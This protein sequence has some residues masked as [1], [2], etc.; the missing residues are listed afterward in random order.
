MF[1]LKLHP[2][3]LA[4][5]FSYIVATIAIGFW[6][7]KRASKS[8]DNYFLGGNTIPWYMLGLS[9]ASGMFD[10]SG[11]MWMVYLL[12]VYGLKSVWIPWLWPT[13]NQIF[14]MV[15]LSV[16]LRRSGVMTGAEW[17]RFRFGDSRG[18]Q[19][20]HLIVVVFALV[21]V[22]GFLAYGFIGI[23]KFTAAFLP[24]ELSED[25]V[26]NANYYG[27][28]I[29]A[30]TTVYVVK[31]GMFSVVFTEV[32][33]FFIMTIACIWVGIIAMIEVSP[34]TLASVVPNGWSDIFFG[35][36]LDLDWSGKLDAANDKIAAD[37]WELFTLFIMMT[38]FKG[39]LQSLAGPA[40]NYDMQRVLSAKTPREAAL[41]SGFV[42]LVL[43]IPRYM[44]IAGLTV[45]A[46]AHFTD[47]LAAQGDKIDFELILPLAMR[48]FIPVGLLGLLISALLAAFMSTYAATVNAAPAYVVNDIYKRYFNPDA[49]EKTYVRVS[50][51]TS[52]IVVVIGTAF[53]FLTDSLN[54]IVQWIVT[55]LYG[56][57]AAANM[58]KWI[59]WR[60]NSY[61]YFWGMTAGMLA[62]GFV[63]QVF[64]QLAQ[65][66]LI[67]VRPAEIFMFPVIL[68]L[69]LAGCILGTL[70][71]PPDD[72]ETLKNF[73]RRVRPWGFWK[74]IHKLVATEYPDIMA[75]RDL[76]R[77]M[78]NVVVGIVWQIGLTAT[79]IFLVIRDYHSLTW[80]V[81]VVLVTS[82]ILKQNWYDRL[83]DYPA[84]LAA[85]RKS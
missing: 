81:G 65:R 57:Y 21:N 38:L 37:G 34:E 10:I 32:L 66:G 69:S 26:M 15:F 12:F 72:V 46:L 3:D 58:L 73:Y 78:F 76:P 7:S 60:F 24:W 82:W 59:W 40:P 41:M 77:D 31:G 50:Y 49:S 51:A 75:N 9:N 61:G 79:G 74:P 4:I 64:T 6:I 63:P 67:A 19:L 14:M 22:I 35:W 70:L 56:G 47:E 42:S 71:T 43:L 44:L 68:L 80:T 62:A 83:V 33:Q 29:T 13:F 45:L 53:G 8:M 20:A 1:D 30:I 54:D 25:S 11:T 27:L 17:I 2:F 48:E 16:W 55:A 84:D 18:A 28:I 23:G 36:H 85:E 52:I 39:V 5:I